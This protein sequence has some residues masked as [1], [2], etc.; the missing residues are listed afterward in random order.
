[1]KGFDA[2]LAV[3]SGRALHVAR[4][5]ELISINGQEPDAWLDPFMAEQAGRP[6]SAQ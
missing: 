3:I 5:H 2:E 1:L 4:M 6:I